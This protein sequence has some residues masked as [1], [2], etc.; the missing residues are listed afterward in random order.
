MKTIYT[1]EDIKIC[2]L[3]SKYE[4][5][6]GGCVETC[7]ALREC[8]AGAINSLKKHYVEQ[9]MN[10]SKNNCKEFKRAFSQKELLEH[11]NR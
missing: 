9:R 10:G 11:L 5:S 8:D 4:T 6:P 3:C 1:K 7:H 2:D